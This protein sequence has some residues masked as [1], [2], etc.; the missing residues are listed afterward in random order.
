MAH[1]DPWLVTVTLLDAAG[2]RHSYVIKDDVPLSEAR[3]LGL[4]RAE[5]EAE[6]AVRG[7]AR[8][9]L[10]TVEVLEINEAVRKNTLRFD[11]T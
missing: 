11:I 4:S 7:G 5:S 3:R 9:D 1:Y 8:I 2:T 6:Q 10:G